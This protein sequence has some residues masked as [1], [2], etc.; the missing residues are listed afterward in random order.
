MSGLDKFG[1]TWQ[2]KEG[3][4]FVE[5]A[6]ELLRGREPLKYKLINVSYKLKS[7]E[8][9]LDLYIN[10]MQDRD[11]VLFEKVVEAQI[12]KDEMR[13]AM[14]AGEVAEIRKIVKQ[15]IATRIALEHVQL[16][17]ETAVIAGE[18]GTSL[19]PVV[20]V[21]SE[22]KNVMKSVMPTLSIELREIEDILEETMLGMGN[23]VESHLSYQVASEEARKILKEAAVVAE[24]RMKETF[25]EL[26]S[27]PAKEEA[28]TAT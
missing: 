17:I 8:S 13:A 9:R 28:K 4:S 11:R 24:Q 25:P 27:A 26:P 18:V 7:L 5:K 1:K 23:V 6:R 14:Y 19:A 15:L 10:K 2:G 22:L 3:P 16:R 20:S 21:V 12:N